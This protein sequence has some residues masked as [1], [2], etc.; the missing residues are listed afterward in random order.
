MS[1]PNQTS[2][3]PA[4]VCRD[5]TVYIEAQSEINRRQLKTKQEVRDHA[6]W[7]ITNRC[8]YGVEWTD[9]LQPAKPIPQT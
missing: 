9:T 6:Q 1:L 8:P 2:E 3:C 4:N 5:C 7:T